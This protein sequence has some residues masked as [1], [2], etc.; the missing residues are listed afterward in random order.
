MKVLVIGATGALGYSTV[1][2]ALHAGHEVRV[3]VRS[4]NKLR[5]LPFGSEVEVRVGDAQEAAAVREAVA[6]CAAIFYCLNVPITR[7]GTKLVPLLQNALEACRTAGA[8]MVFPGNV[9]VFGK[10]VAGH[11]VAETQDFAPCSRKGRI[12]VQQ[13]RTLQNSGV[14]YTI[15]RLP[16]FYGPNVSNKL[17]GAPFVR[18]LRGKPLWWLGGR[19]DVPVEYVFIEDAARA[20]VEAGLAES[21]D[22][23][24][25]HV[26]G[27]SVTTPGAFFREVARAAG[28][29][30][31]V[32]ALPPFLVRC[33]G[34]FHAEARELTDILH[35]WSDPIL[36]DGTKYQ[37]RF[38]R[39]PRTPYH[40]GIRRTLDGGKENFA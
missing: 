30:A 9:W 37:K 1:R 17:M 16:E 38:G 27:H 24:T 40:E 28:S 32:R 19:L 29:G 10:G 31:P 15:V 23:E 36:L 33:A 4:P 39:I 25:F 13:E 5:R 2:K 35:L 21:V 22:G 11:R 14:R 20:M 3:L 12:R 8:R 6:G 18:A 7:W 34:L 26:P